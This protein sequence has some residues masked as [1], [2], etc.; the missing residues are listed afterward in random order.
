M[1]HTLKGKLDTGEVWLD[2]E[3]L[4]PE[5]SQKCRNH[6]PDG[7]CWGYFGSG[8]AQLSLAIVLKLTGQ[9]AGYQDFKDK[10]IA[11]IPQTNFETEFEY[12]NF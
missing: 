3:L 5:E 10:V 8:P 2:G 7:F 11:A 12:P 4:S 6:S 1:K 9:P